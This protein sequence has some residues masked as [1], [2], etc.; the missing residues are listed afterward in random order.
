MLLLQ[1]S[2]AIP[3]TPVELILASSMVTKVVLAMLVVLSL[4]SWGI[5][6]AK[7][8]EFRRMRTAALAF[9]REFARATSLEQAVA[10]AKKAPSSP[11]NRV[12]ARAVNYLREV[13]Q[14]ATAEAAA[15]GAAKPTLTASQ[16]EAL[17]LLLDAETTSERDAL[18]RFIPSLAVI[19]SVS[20]LMGLLGTVL[21]VISAF[22]GIATKGSGNLAAV[23][24]GVAEA[25]IATAT[26]LAVAIPAVFGYNIFAARLNRFDG[27][28]EGFGS[29]I[30]ALMAREGRI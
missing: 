28:L 26:A 30:I 20:P 14:R 12:F 10:A 16:V 3:S 22:I 21:G 18:S 6:L 24:P 13:T 25:L 19:G 5:M 7:W 17:R 2:A 1:S 11:Y 27:E 15:T 29:E 8:L 23:A 4:L 9:T